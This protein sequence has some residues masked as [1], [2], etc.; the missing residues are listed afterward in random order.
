V[1]EVARQLCSA[2][3]S[4]HSLG[5]IHR[6]IKPDNVLLVRQPDDRDLVKVLDFGI[7]KVKESAKER[8]KEISGITMTKTG[9]VVGTPQYM[10]PEQ[11]MG[12]P[13]DQLDGRSDLYSMGVL[14]YEALTGELPFHADTPLGYLLHH[15]HTLPPSPLERRP[16]L[17]LAE[18]IVKIVMKALEKD[19]A[20]RFQSAREIILALTA[21]AETFEEET[22]IKKVYTSRTQR[23]DLSAVSPRASPRNGESLQEERAP[24]SVAVATPPP[25]GSTPEVDAGQRPDASWET[26]EATHGEGAALFSRVRFGQ[27]L[28][29]AKQKGVQ[30]GAIVLLVAISAGLGIK[31]WHRPRPVES[32]ISTPMAETRVS[33]PAPKTTL[34]ADR[35]TV[36]KGES[37][38]LNWE[39]E[40]A[41]KLDLQPGVGAVQAKGQ[42]TVRPEESTTYTLTA[43]GPGGRKTASALVTVI[44]P[45]PP[46]RPAP[47]TKLS[48]AD[49]AKLTDNLAIAEFHMNRANYD[50]AIEAYQEALKI[51]ASN[52]QAREGLRKARQLRETLKSIIK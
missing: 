50:D 36:E 16:N 14:I 6:D 9:F 37:V 38:T 23:P 44:T 19:P 28:E 13:G 21:A 45:P 12:K 32:P 33:H 25:G 51:D 24:S 15:V 11:A 17:D 34:T 7:A 41:T 5:M 20:D 46:T 52:R 49:K 4:A 1:I 27:F 48:P 35:G 8:G 42:T 10:S 40:N 26:R 43:T 3:D 29:V 2:L 39:S 47:P 30:L 31:W 18:P 22:V